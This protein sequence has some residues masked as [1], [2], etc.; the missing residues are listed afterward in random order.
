MNQKWSRKIYSID[1]NLIYREYLNGFDNFK[2]VFKRF[3]PGRLQRG[4]N[5]PE[6]EV[7][8]DLMSDRPLYRPS[9]FVQPV[10]YDRILIELLSMIYLYFS[11]WSSVPLERRTNFGFKNFK[12]FNLL[13]SSS[14]SFLGG[15][16]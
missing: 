15:Q 13:A 8:Q 11:Y 12:F 2:T 7:L 9:N 4:S 3:Q 1:V 14:Q 5:L 6:M 10:E 16:N